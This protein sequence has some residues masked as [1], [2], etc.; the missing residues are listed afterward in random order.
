MSDH[1]T[2]RK[3]P[4]TLAHRAEYYSMRAL[5]AGLGRL[6]WETACTIGER[7]G[8][9]G[10]RPLGIRRDVVERQIAAAFPELDHAGVQKIARASYRHLGRTSVEAALLGNLGPERILEM[11]ESVEGWEHI[12]AATS[13]GRGTIG[14][15]AHHGNWEVLGAFLAARGVPPEVVV[16]GMG[17]RLFED[18]LNANR[19][20][21]GLTVMHDSVAV[22]RTMK[23]MREGRFVAFLS[24]QGVMGL[25][26]SFVPFF[27]RPAKTPRGFA[28]FAL[29]FDSPVVFMDMLR[30]P[31]GRFRIV[32]EP[33]E[34]ERTGD[35]EKDVDAMVERYSAI[36]EKWVRQYPEQYFWQ[37]RRWRRQPPGTP[38]ELRDPALRDPSLWT[39]SK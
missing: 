6:S 7:L 8:E 18:Y 14:V 30:L 27:G 13:A 36:L 22:R 3:K 31:D 2:R 9:M 38:V 1:E 32:F 29:R 24:D 17:N 19:A 28:V 26:S 10:Y 33:V 20:R 25:A 15:A 12:V 11:V 34:A 16:R 23:A 37:H 5:I 39:P 21:L 4:P 35:R